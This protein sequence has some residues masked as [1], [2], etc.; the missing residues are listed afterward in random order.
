MVASMQNTSEQT[1]TPILRPK[2]APIGHVRK[3]PTKELLR[4]AD[5]YCI[6]W[7][8]KHCLLLSFYLRDEQILIDI[9]NMTVGLSYLFH[10][11]QLVQPS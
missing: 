11:I 3:Q 9:G 5:R 10:H 6:C 2:R 1:I 4:A 8:W 7:L